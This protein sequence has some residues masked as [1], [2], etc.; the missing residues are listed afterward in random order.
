MKKNHENHKKIV[1][2]IEEH[3]GTKTD[4]EIEH[5]IRGMSFVTSATKSLSLLNN[6]L[7]PII[8]RISWMSKSSQ[9]TPKKLFTDAQGL[10]ESSRH[11]HEASRQLGW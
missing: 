6:A 9:E 10:M 11:I 7:S 8:D 2:I 4:D 1:E 3:N 5:K